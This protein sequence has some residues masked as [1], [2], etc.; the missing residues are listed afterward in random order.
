M[1]IYSRKTILKA[2]DILASSD[3]GDFDRFLLEHDLEGRIGGG[4]VRDR[5]NS[6]ARYLLEHPDDEEDGRNLTDLIV[7]G[8]IDGAIRNCLQ[9]GQFNHATFYERYANLNR[10]LERD[11]FTVEDGRIRRTLPQALDLPR[12]DDEVHT[13]LQH[14]GFAVPVGHLDQ[15]ITA[16]GRGEWAGANGQLR[17][18]AE[19]I[20][21]THGSRSR[22]PL[23]QQ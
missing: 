15:A 11:G 9:Y 14:Y 21:A 23:A 18:F 6:F 1:P 19:Q 17:T 16:H 5:A 7:D 13:L 4:S 10:A 22:V 2:T 12:A 8:L 20:H 3:H